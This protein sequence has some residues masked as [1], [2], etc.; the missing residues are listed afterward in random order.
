M[1]RLIKAPFER[2]ITIAFILL[3]VI[4]ISLML[5]GR[6]G[7]RTSQQQKPT[8]FVMSS[9]P[10]KWGEANMLEITSG[11]AE[12][13]ALLER[14]GQSNNLV[15]LDDFATLGKPGVDPLLLIQPRALAP[16][17]LVQ[18]DGWIRAGGSAVIFADPVLDWPS[19]LPLGDQRRPLFTS[20]LT[21]M[22]KH[23]G[24]ELAMPV[25]ENAASPNVTMGN[26]R[27]APKS[28]GIWLDAKNGKASAKCQVRKDE[29][30]AFC[31]VGKGR[32]LLV[33][34]ADLLEPEQWTD[35]V[36]TAGTLDW[37]NGSLAAMRRSESF[38]GKLWEIQE[39]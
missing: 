14:L 37:L 31:L 32:A 10:L 33:A 17:E 3:G 19:N 2:R 23:W 18:L 12:P 39:Q 28:A 34:D 1:L 26:F 15:L 25:G 27:I 20:L 36:M 5:F 7:D 24:L 22:F 9:I 21:P 4:I 6:L 29:F 38:P 8:L 11:K 35:S 16:R 30:V 13:S